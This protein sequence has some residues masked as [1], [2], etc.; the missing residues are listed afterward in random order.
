MDGDRPVDGDHP[1]ITPFYLIFV[2]KI[3]IPNFSFL[4]FLE[5][6]KKFLVV[7][8]AVVGGWRPIL[9]SSFGPS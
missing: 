6:A 1:T 3:N 8:G 5:V 9:M 4:P 7:G 2:S